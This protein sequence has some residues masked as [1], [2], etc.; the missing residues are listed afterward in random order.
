MNMR[1]GQ[2]SKRVCWLVRYSSYDYYLPEDHTIEWVF[3]PPYGSDG[4]P[5][6]LPPPF[7]STFDRE[8]A[9]QVSKSLYKAGTLHVVNT[10]WRDPEGFVV[11]K[12]PII[13]R[14]KEQ[15]L[16]GFDQQEVS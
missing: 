3:T 4:F 11:K 14:W 9:E 1:W 15:H 2:P 5:R 13:K 16:A 7:F 12:L 10:R 6:K 8:E